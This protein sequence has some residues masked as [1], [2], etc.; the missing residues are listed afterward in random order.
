MFACKVCAE[1]DKRINDLQNE[2]AYLRELA[3]PSKLNVTIPAIH[4][5]ADRIMSASQ[6]EIPS[7]SLSDEEIT[8]ERIRLLSGTY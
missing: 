7:E 6:D 2:V 3:N 4:S 5:E 1:K 8:S